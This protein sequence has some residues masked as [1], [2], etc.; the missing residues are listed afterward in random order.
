MIKRLVIIAFLTG[1]GH[2][3]TLLS[4]KYISKFVENDTIAI[5]GEIDSLILLIV[6]IIAFGLQLSSTRDIALIEDWKTELQEAQKARFTLSLILIGFGITGF[7]FTKNYLFFTAPIIALNADYAL[8]GRGKPIMGGFVA[9]I[10]VLTPSL[11]LVIASVY[12]KSDIVILFVG[13]LVLAY[14]ITGIIVSKSLG[15]KYL[16]KPE[17]KSL[18]KYLG[19]INIG[20]ASFSLFFI[21]IGILNVLSYFYSSQTIA[22]SYI[23]LK[24]YMI[25]KGV[26]RIIVQS[27]FQELKEKMVSLKVDYFSMIAGVI[28]LNSIIFFPNILIPLL[29][30]DKFEKYTTT[31]IILGIAGFLSS[32]TTS[33]GTLLLLNRQDK[34]YSKILISAAI[35][36]IVSGIIFYF[37]I[38][39]EPFLIALAIL[40]GELIISV[41][42]VRALKEINFIKNRIKVIFPILVFSVIFIPI[43][44]YNLQDVL[45]LSISFIFYIIAIL[46]Y[47]KLTIKT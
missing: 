40:I 34:Q 5:I 44:L 9:L 4:L 46:I 27:F 21:G 42:N 24:L 13:S 16:V 11:A 30:D 29:F 43:K 38:G 32:I 36:S 31:F 39:E 33:T 8:Y 22:I 14:L 28:F 3:T 18:K 1:F 19:N 12:F 23:A 41:F 37:F 7:M 20:V 45:T 47:T 26:R 25:F 15:V 17:L 10:R 6:A 2:I 35:I